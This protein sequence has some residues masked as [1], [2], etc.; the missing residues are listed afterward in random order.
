MIHVCFS[1]HDKTGRYSK[2][3]GTT[4]LSIFENTNS[5]VTAHILHDNTLTAENRDKFIYLAGRYGQ[6]VKFYNV[7]ELCA[8]KISE[9]LNFAPEVKNAYVSIG[10]FYRLLIPQIIPSDVDKIIYLD[11]DIIVNLDLKELWQ[12][13]LGDK[14]SAAVPE[15]LLYK[16]IDNMK[17]WFPLCAYGIVKAEDYFNAGV[18][19]MDLNLFRNAESAIMQGIRFCAKNPRY[20][21]YHDQDVLNYCFSTK[22]LKLSDKFNRPAQVVR[23]EDESPAKKIYH[24]AGGSFGVGLGLDINDWLNR[25]WMDYFIKSP[26]FDTDS[27]GRLYEGFKKLQTEQKKSEINLSATM[28]GKTRAFIVFEDE[29]DKLV[30]NFSVKNEEEIFVIKTGTPLEKIIELMNA[31]HGEKVFFIMLPEFPFNL[32]TEAGFVQGKDFLNAYDF[33]SDIQ[34]KQ[35][36]QL[37]K[38]M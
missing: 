23:L 5:E 18:L 13:D 17:H 34:A 30:E 19:L 11:S 29:L 31:L 21:G 14:I 3:T 15:I 35:A 36:Y 24:Y 38:E 22:Y 37:I 9:I 32:L 12:I 20:Q 2:F 28:S 4:I 16:T 1:L 26:W 8:D 10:T 27:M 6:L 7:E 33:F 25:L